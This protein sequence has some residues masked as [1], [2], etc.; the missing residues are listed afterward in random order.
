MYEQKN[1][2]TALTA[3]AT[4]PRHPSKVAR[5]ASEPS[6]QRARWNKA[7]ERVGASLAADQEVRASEHC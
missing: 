6:E 3:E 4:E 5:S 2:S 1:S 7:G